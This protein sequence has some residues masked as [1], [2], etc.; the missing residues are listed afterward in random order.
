MKRL[1]VSSAINGTLRAAASK[2][3]AQRAI[4]IATV[5]SSPSTLHGVTESSDVE[6][7]LQAAA[8]LGAG[9]THS[10]DALYIDPRK[11]PLHHTV[12]C[13]EAGLTVR[14]FAPVAALFGERFS[15]TG[16]PSL[17]KRPITMIEEALVQLGATCST[18]GGYLPMTVQGPIRGGTVRI[19]GGISSQLLTGLLISLPLVQEDSVIE[20][21]NLKSRPYIDMTLDIIRA[22]GVDITHRDYTVFSVPGSQA[23]SG[24]DYTVE[25]D[26]SGA[27]FFLVAGALSGSVTVTNLRNDSPQADRLICDVLDRCGAVV[28]TADDSV[29]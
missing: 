4:A 22:F 5:A 21:I 10:D 20:V 14:M 11:R 7:S 3:M 23:Y 26:W 18:N 2:S 25:G 1:V 16:A 13:S 29:S 27:A 6:A 19:D 17:M 15:F 9:I 24:I 28:E 8:S 12:N